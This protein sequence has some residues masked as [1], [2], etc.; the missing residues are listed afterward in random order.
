MI[1]LKEIIDN[2]EYLDDWED[3]Y[4]YIIELGNSLENFPEE[5][6]NEKTKVS[7]CVSQVWISSKIIT[8]KN[9]KKISFKGDSDAHIVKGLIT[10]V[11]SIYSNKTP[12]EIL[13]LSGEEILKKLNLDDHLSPQRSNGLFSMLERIKNDAR[14]NL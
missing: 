9:E 1:E 6:K 4:K 10:I 5:Y 2:F 3:R 8:K 12:Q 13:S 7:G 11:L 14:S